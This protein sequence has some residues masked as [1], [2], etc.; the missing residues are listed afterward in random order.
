MSFGQITKKKSS[1]DSHLVLNIHSALL[2]RASGYGHMLPLKL[3]PATCVMTF[4][5][6]IGLHACM[7]IHKSSDPLLQIPQFRL[8]R[9]A[10]LGTWSQQPTTTSTSLMAVEASKLGAGSSAFPSKLQGVCV[11]TAKQGGCVSWQFGKQ[12]HWHKHHKDGDTLML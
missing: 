12:T 2:G 9:H 7:H 8:G 5:S 4:F 6:L 11:T 3:P 10:C 1:L